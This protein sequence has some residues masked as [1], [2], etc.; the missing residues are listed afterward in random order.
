MQ[1]TFVASRAGESCTFLTKVRRGVEVF[2]PDVDQYKHYTPVLV[3]D[4]ISAV[5]TMIETVKLLK[6]ANIK[7]PVYIGVHAVFAG[8]GYED[9]QASGAAKIVTCSTIPHP[10]NEIDLNRL[11]TKHLRY[12]EA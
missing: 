8:N 11:L 10:S 4:I 2:V 1:L 9:L 6:G 12:K 7:T 5:Q 3:N